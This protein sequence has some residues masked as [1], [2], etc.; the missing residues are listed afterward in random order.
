VKTKNACPAFLYLIIAISL[1]LSLLAGCAAPAGNDLKNAPVEEQAPL[2][3]Y[4]VTD[5]TA[6]PSGDWGYPTPYGH[7]SRGPGYIRMHYV[8]ETLVWKD[9]NG[10]IPQLA[11]EWKYSAGEKAYQF[12]LQ[13]NVKWHDGS[14]F[15][16]EDVV[17][18]F[19]YTRDHPYQWVDNTIVKSA[20]AVD[21]YTVKL[22]LNT[23][24]AP[25]LQDV[26]GN[27]PIMPKHIW[28]DIT[29]PVK[30]V[31]PKALVGTGPY[32]LTDYNKEQ[33]SYLYQANDGY[34]LRKPHVKEIKFVRNSREMS[35]SALKSGA[36]NAAVEIPAEIVT[37]LE[38]SG[39]TV[40][41]CPLSWSAKLTINHQ[42]EPLSSREF[43]QA[44]AY[45]IDRNKLV[46]ISLRGH[47]IAGSSGL[48]PPTSPWFNPELPQYDH[49]PAKAK[50]LLE[51]LGYR[52]E[53]GFMTKDG[54]QL[55]LELIAPPNFKD[56]GQF[57][58]GQ[59][60][61][62]GIKIDFK[63]LEAKTVDSRVQNWNF[64]LSIYGHGGLYEPAILKKL[65]TGNEFLSARYTSNQALTQL[66]QSQAGEMDPV[67]RKQKVYEIQK[68]YAEDMPALT[69]YYPKWYTAHDG[70]LRLYYTY[71]GVGMGIPSPLNR[72]AF[73]K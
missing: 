6:D 71:D 56:V 34:Y 1:F 69:L 66:I 40:V 72:M 63:T 61:A 29:E 44:I 45:A 43:R 57:V 18:T 24:Y 19:N 11:R 53:E 31:D 37:D 22:L 7:Y 41:T 67:K 12:T 65:I 39:I 49:D 68:L 25:F 42:K 52:M 51:G 62:A 8:F 23:P 32:K 16:A 48:M 58:T 3:S 13:E 50:A 47:A 73:V 38:K 30:F 70:K 27:Q 35:A 28:E 36:I 15:T 26:A 10:F 55:K 5:L 9:A 33:G 4:S 2:Q 20:E 60:E 54:K 17:F 14:D 21:K 64:D 46:Q 59:L